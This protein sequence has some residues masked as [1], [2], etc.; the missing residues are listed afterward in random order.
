MSLRI[1]PEQSSLYDSNYPAAPVR[2]ERYK[3]GFP[4]INAKTKNDAFFGLGYMHAH[5][6]MFQVQLIRILSSGRMTECFGE[7]PGL[8]DVDRYFKTYP[9][10]R[11]EPGEFDCI[12]ADTRAMLDAYIAG[13]NTPAAE[14]Y[15]PLEMRLLGI[16]PEPWDYQDMVALLRI[17]AYV[18]LASMGASVKEDMVRTLC[19][20]RERFAVF[21]ELFSEEF[22]HYDPSWLSG[23]SVM[24][25]R[26][27]ADLLESAGGSNNWAASG[28]LCSGGKLLFCNDPHLEVSRLPSIWY[29]AVLSCPGFYCAGI[30]IPGGAAV[31]SGCNGQLSWGITFG[32][33]D[34]EDFFIEDC[35]NGGYL[36]DG[37]RHDFKRREEQIRT[38][39][40]NT[41]GFSVFE[42]DHGILQ[43]NPYNEGRLLC[44]KWIGFDLSGIASVDAFC[45]LSSAK[46]VQE[47]MSCVENIDIFNLNWVFA[48]ADGNIGYR[49]SGAVPVRGGG[50]S[51]LLPIPGWS[52]HYDWQGPVE[53]TQMPSCYN[54]DCGYIV[55]A[56]NRIENP[57]G[58]AVQT[59]PLS[60]DRA[61][62]IEE[63]LKENLPLDVG[64]MQEIQY[65]VYSPQAQRVLSA[66][67]PYLEKSERGRRLLAWDRK[68]TP[69][70]R[71]ASEYDI[72]YR[73]LMTAVCSGLL[74]DEEEIAEI[75]DNRFFFFV[76]HRRIEEE[77]TKKDGVFSGIDWQAA[78]DAA[79]KRI[80]PKRPPRWG[81][82]N[83]LHMRHLLFGKTPLGFLW[84]A[85]PF[86][87][88]G[89]YSTVHQ[90]S[91]FKRGTAAEST[92]GPSYHQIT[93]LKEGRYYSNMPG[94]ASGRPCSRFY[95]RGIRAWLH[96]RYFRIDIEEN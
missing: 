87:F 53:A 8:L 5:D 31:A 24:L 16:E 92:A 66:L 52:S 35:K 81:R 20:D 60:A 49:M 14:G 72:F 10:R 71:T 65:D 43:G 48:D 88:R 59:L 40:G 39:K 28:R 21:K 93:D 73:E 47:G 17:M 64:T 67:K 96:K 61:D 45:R 75:Y 27:P 26:G 44:R 76:N 2:I 7:R 19:A 78:V 37:R 30:S 80:R 25:N 18:G 3:T 54:P 51:G 83:R 77:W 94:G 34:A 6:R 63:L 38:K 36:R 1:I 79:L 68:F 41:Y 22:Q 13:I 62:R 89:H 12:S 82:R 56:N 91:T 55:T 32:A 9:F 86:S 58:P 69:D 85:G 46:T 90:G 50:L 33:A 15:R 42:S 29:E 70:S 4:R 95:R 11:T 74:F 84:N 23:L 57:N